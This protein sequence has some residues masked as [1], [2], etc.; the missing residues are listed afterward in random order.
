MYYLNFLTQDHY[1]QDSGTPMYS[2]IVDTDIH[3][4]GVMGGFLELSN[5]LSASN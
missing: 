1:H 2:G 5:W 4:D 3:T